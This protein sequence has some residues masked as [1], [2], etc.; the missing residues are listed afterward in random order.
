[1]YG[2]FTYIYHINQLNVGKYTSPMDPMGM[3]ILVAIA[4]KWGEFSSS[5]NSYPAAKRKTPGRTA[6]RTHVPWFSANGFPWVFLNLTYI[7]S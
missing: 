1:M 5:R 4:A 7:E 2:I 3:F 6:K